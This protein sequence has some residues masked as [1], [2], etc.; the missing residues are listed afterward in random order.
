MGKTASSE[1]V[2]A[3]DACR[4][5]ASV[6]PGP[7]V[8]KGP[9]WGLVYVEAHLIAVDKP[10]GWLSV[11]GRGAARVDHLAARVQARHAGALVVHRLDQATSG[12]NLFARGP[13]MQRALSRQFAQRQ[14]SKRYEALASGLVTD[15][16]VSIDAPLAPDW[17]RRPRQRAEV[18]DG[19]PSLTRYRVLGRD[20]A[21][22]TTRLSLEPVTGRSHQLRVHLL[23]LG[24]PLVG[25]AIYPR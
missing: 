13:A 17:P 21:A 9:E 19:R 16:A 7:A 3:D 12:L 5:T 11:P 22:G 20:T 25:D 15:D 23:H 4:P 6:D 24:H 8:G 10:A 18:E 1:R 2:G 14:V